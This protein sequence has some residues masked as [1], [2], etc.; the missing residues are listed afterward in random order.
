MVC[1]ILV[2]SG[3]VPFASPWDQVYLC[4]Y[5]SCPGC[6]HM[7]FYEHSPLVGWQAVVEDRL[8]DTTGCCEARVR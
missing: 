6:L 3:Y 4:L 8:Q 2:G 5:L 7:E 1:L